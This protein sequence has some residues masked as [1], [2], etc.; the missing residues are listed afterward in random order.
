[1]V[2]AV[3]AAAVADRAVDRVLQLPQQVRRRAKAAVPVVA[4]AEEAA[5]VEVVA[6]VTQQLLLLHPEIRMAVPH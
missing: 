1:M 4:A 2:V 5:A 6:V 3:A